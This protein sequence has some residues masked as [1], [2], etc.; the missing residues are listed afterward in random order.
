MSVQ[1]SVAGVRILAE[2]RCSASRQKSAAPSQ[3]GEIRDG[4]GMN[5]N[6]NH[7]PDAVLTCRESVAVIQIE[8]ESVDR[9]QDKARIGMWTACLQVK[10]KLEL[11]K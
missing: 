2:P 11:I 8:S 9:R 4:Q 10:K 3:E 6:P 5:Q 7:A 1:A